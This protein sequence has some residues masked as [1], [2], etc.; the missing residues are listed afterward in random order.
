MD[1]F[2]AFMLSVVVSIPKSLEKIIEA[3]S[4]R[5]GHRGVC[6]MRGVGGSCTS[7]KPPFV[8]NEPYL[9][10]FVVLTSDC[11][12]MG[13]A[14]RF[15]SCLTIISCRKTSGFSSKVSISSKRL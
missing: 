1:I 2:D 5:L 3:C 12:V 8:E 4:K 14:Y 13:M 11:V 7:E 10:L 9:R 15:S 6:L